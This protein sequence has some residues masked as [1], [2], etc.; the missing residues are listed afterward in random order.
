MAGIVLATSMAAAG[1]ICGRVLL[2]AALTAGGRYMFELWRGYDRAR[3]GFAPPHHDH[4]MQR[5]PHP[6]HAPPHQMGMKMPPPHRSEYPPAPAHL[7][8]VPGWPLPPP[9]PLHAHLRHA[10]K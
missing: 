5:Q 4:L 7:L 6:K 10:W 2:A 9:N 1:A 3:A 8:G